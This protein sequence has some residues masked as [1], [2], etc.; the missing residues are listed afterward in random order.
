[1]KRHFM[2]DLETMGIRPTSAILSIGVTVFDQESILDQFYTPVSLQSC[3]DAGLTT[4]KS[5]E[6]W[7]SQQTDAARL[8]WQTPD[9]PELSK[10]LSEMGAWMR[11]VA[12]ESY[13]CPWGNGADFDLVLLINAYNALNADAPWKF[14]NHHCFRTMKNMFKVQAPLKV[15]THHNALDDAVNQTNHLHV[16]LRQYGIVLP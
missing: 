2:I 9:A 8:A 1:M 12:P 6:I 15:G 14:Y 11:G 16:I 3:L 4:D 13:I 10:A 7:W 5:T